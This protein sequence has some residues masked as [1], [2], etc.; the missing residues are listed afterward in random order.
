M[1]YKIIKNK[2]I[3]FI[4][5]VCLSKTNKE[6]TA[7]SNEYLFKLNAN[8]VT[9]ILFVIKKYAEKFIVF[10]TYINIKSR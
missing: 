6:K 8:I 9:H 3:K 4:E 10:I 1:M 5:F 7:K 2:Y